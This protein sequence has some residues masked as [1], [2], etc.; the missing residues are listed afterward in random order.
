M[1]TRIL[2]CEDDPNLGSLLR[3]YLVAKDY[4]VD[5]MPDGELGYQ[6]FVENEYDLC[7]FDVMMPNKDGFTLASDIRKK[8]TKV[9]II[10]LTVKALK[11]DILEGF[12][13]GADDYI[14]KPFS[15]EELLFR[16]EAIMRRVNM[17]K[18]QLGTTEYKFGRFMFDYQKQILTF[19]EERHKLTTK[20]AEMLRALLQNANQILE[21]NAALKAIW[22]E[23]TYFNARSMDVYI[24]KLR[25]ILQQDP[26][27]SIVNIHGKGYKLVIPKD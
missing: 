2:L 8:D 20:E 7:I 9:P 11:Q 19:D 17:Q 18:L 13:I 4:E 12:K 25:K 3:E 22:G 27:I 14:T 15:M 6:A 5:L 26:D 24:T 21:R 1:N 16:I 10:F 23:V